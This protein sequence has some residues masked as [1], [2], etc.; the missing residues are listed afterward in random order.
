M[1]TVYTGPM[2]SGKSTVLIEEYEWALK[3]YAKREIL[4][5]K[6]SKDTRTQTK[7]RARNVDFEIDAI[8]ISRFEDIAC[9]ITDE[10]KL[11]FIDEIQFIEGNYMILNDLSVYNGIE[12]YIAGLKQDSNLAPFG[13]MPYIL[14]IANEIVTLK[15]NCKICCK[16]GAEYTYRKSKNTDTILIGDTK[17]YFPICV[18]CLNKLENIVK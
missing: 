8:V 7:I 12:I 5:F 11:I 17:E 9:F 18:K 16:F 1:I 6:P 13:C 4:C 10:T 14:A 15:A 2:F 3:K